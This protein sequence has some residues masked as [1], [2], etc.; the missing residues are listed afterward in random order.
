M[1]TK[2][3]FLGLLVAALSFSCTKKEDDEPAKMTASDAAVNAKMNSSNDDVSKIIEDQYQLTSDNATTGRG[4]ESAS[5][6]LPSCATVVRN[7]A[8]GTMPTV[9]QTVTKTITFATPFCTLPNGSI[10]TGQII[11][12]FVYDPSLTTHVITYQFVNFYHNAIKYEGTKTFSWV[13]SSGNAV[14]ANPHAIVTM[15]MDMTAT[16]NSNVYHRV[17]QR[18]NEISSD[19]GTPNWANWTDNVYRVTGNWVTTFP[20]GIDQAS[21]ITTPLEVSMPCAF[22]QT[23]A[24]SKGVITITKNNVSS[25][26]DYGDG[27]CD[28]VAIYTLYGISYNIN[29]GHN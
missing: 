5:V 26:L 25:T 3:L 9:G 19:G 8:F 29:V 18:V 4:T 24:I 23:C 13:W 14:N 28:N 11:M 17:G 16:I 15:N 1:K 7:P 21:D 12:S 2:I 22:Q 27:S 20:D 6:F 10:V